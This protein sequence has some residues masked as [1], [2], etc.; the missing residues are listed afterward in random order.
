M[1]VGYDMI[2]D[3]RHDL[4]DTGMVDTCHHIFVQSHKYTTPRVNPDVNFGL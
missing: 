1:Y 3:I 4:Y 2:Y